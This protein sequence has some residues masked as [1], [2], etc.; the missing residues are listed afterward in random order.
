MW[1]KGKNKAK[2]ILKMA[3]IVPFII[4]AI[5]AIILWPFLEIKK[6]KKILKMAKIVPFIIFAI[7]AI[8]LW[9]F[10]RRIEMGLLTIGLISAIITSIVG[11]LFVVLAPRNIILTYVDEAWG[12][13]VMR[14]GARRKL[15]LQWAGYVAAK[16][17]PPD[18]IQKL[19]AENRKAL[20]EI[21]RDELRKIKTGDWDIIPHPDPEKRRRTLRQRIFG[22]LH[23][24]GIPGADRVLTYNLRWPGIKLGEGGSLAM[25]LYEEELDQFL[26]RGDLYVLKMPKVETMFPERFGVTIVFQWRM[27]IG[28]PRKAFFVGPPNPIENALAIAAGWFRPWVGNKKFD[29]L[30]GLKGKSLELGVFDEFV[31]GSQTS[32]QLLDAI[33]MK[34]EGP[35]QI[36]EVIAPQEVTEA[37]VA[38]RKQEWLAKA[39]SESVMR[40]Y[41]N[42]LAIAQ[43]KTV[44]E[45]QQEFSALSVAER[46]KQLYPFLEEMAR[47][48]LALDKNAY[49]EIRT[50]GG[51]GDG[52]G[53]AVREFIA[54]ASGLI[55]KVVKEERRPK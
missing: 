44:E 35:I 23:L 45:V 39:S 51:K 1:K 9:L 4:F 49:F 7:G 16:D 32:V 19:A 31:P 27:R 25:I 46:Q 11:L 55:A 18:T 24:V 12:R 36:Q 26:A 20:K 37:L 28:N 17:L 8:I 21:S 3:K 53:G 30:L 14:F 10:F 40:F 42:S 54:T 43:G 13:I 29:Q 52:A 41:L 50:E 48:R 2:K 15:L 5:G 34:I 47:I 33:G 38:Q 22:G 6:A